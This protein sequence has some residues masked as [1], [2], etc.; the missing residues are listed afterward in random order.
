M[1]D[2]AA[3]NNSTVW[4]KNPRLRILAAVGG[5][6]LLLLLVLFFVG[7]C[8]GRAANN[9][10]KPFRPTRTPG[11]VS[12]SGQ[13]ITITFSELNG[14]PAVYANQRI[15]MTGD[16]VKILPP[17]CRVYSGPLF[18]WGLIA[19]DL[20]LNA[21]GFEEL[22]KKLPDGLTMTVEGIWRQYTGPLG[23]GKEA[24]DG[25]TWYLQV[26][27]IIS[28]NPLP[29]LGGT[30]FPTSVFPVVTQ[31]PNLP[32]STSTPPAGTLPPGTAVPTQPPIGITPLPTDQPG[33]IP[34][35]TPSPAAGTPTP[36]ATAGSGFSSPT[37]NPGS[38]PTPSPQPGST[39]TLPASGTG[40]PTPTPTPTAT[41][42]GFGTSTPQPTS[43]GYPPPG[44]RTPAPPTSTPYPGG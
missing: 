13:A 28:P 20:Q 16:Y 9:G 17:E 31:D 27:R 10:L 4:H 34:S 39:A 19:E 18:A 14:D 12:I 32:L 40:T 43:P 3:D 35:P 24:A 26:E 30:P 29:G 15:R 36:T 23:C 22:V 37:P 38:S 33:L 25:T 41:I 8:N 21:Q 5:V 1:D 11:E 7:S 6:L 44:T 42:P 2:N